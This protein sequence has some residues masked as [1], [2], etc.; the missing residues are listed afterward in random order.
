MDWKRSLFVTGN[1]EIGFVL[2]VY[3]P[4]II[5][6][7]FRVFQFASGIEPNMA[8][9]WKSE[10]KLTTFGYGEGVVCDLYRNCVPDRSIAQ[11]AGVM[12]QDIHFGGRPLDDLQ[13]IG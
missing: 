12:L 9:V 8:A 10:R 1:F 2:E 5:G 11:T 3:L 13:S 7:D 6:K 4:V